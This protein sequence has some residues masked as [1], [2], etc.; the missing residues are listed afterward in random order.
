MI[1]GATGFPGGRDNK[2]P[3]LQA[4]IYLSKVPAWIRR[5]TGAKDNAFEALAVFA[6]AVCMSVDKVPDE[7][8]E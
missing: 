5:V 7:I 4:E 3:R 1:A 2:N 6:I 8:R